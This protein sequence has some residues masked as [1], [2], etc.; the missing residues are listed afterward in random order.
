MIAIKTINDASEWEYES[1]DAVELIAEWITS[2]RVLWFAIKDEDEEVAKLART[3]LTDEIVTGNFF[4][5]GMN[6]RS[7]TNRASNQVS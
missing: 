5:E 2:F 4:K 3:V 6:E 7:D 1:N